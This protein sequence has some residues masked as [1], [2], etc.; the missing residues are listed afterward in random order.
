[1]WN[2]SLVEFHLLI[3]R[4]KET[5]YPV[6]IAF[7]SSFETPLKAIVDGNGELLA[8]AWYDNNLVLKQ[9]FKQGYLPIVKPNKGRGRKIATIVLLFIGKYG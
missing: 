2:K 1:L 8:D 6:A 3:R 4:A 9:M 5:I 7:G